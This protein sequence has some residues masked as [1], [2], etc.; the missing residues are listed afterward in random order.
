MIVVF[1]RHI[2]S[3]NLLG[4][5]WA[6]SHD[7]LWWT[8]DQFGDPADFEWCR[9]NK[10]GGALT[11]VNDISSDIFRADAIIDEDG[12]DLA[13]TMELDELASNSLYDTKWTRFD[14]SDVGHGGIA[15]IRRKTG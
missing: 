6:L 15:Q 10:R 9:S 2:E 4:V 3:R 11:V 13:L 1:V 5:F 12:C 8:V 14:F 7:E